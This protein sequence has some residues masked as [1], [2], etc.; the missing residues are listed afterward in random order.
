MKKFEE[1]PQTALKH[2]KEYDR[3]EMNQEE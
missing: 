3:E 1:F 2:L